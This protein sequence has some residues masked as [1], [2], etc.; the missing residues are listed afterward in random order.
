MSKPYHL[1]FR[2]GERATFGALAGLVLGFGIARNL[3]AIVATGLFLQ[4]YAITELPLVFVTGAGV[5]AGCWVIFERL[6]RATGPRRARSIASTL[7]TASLLLCWGLLTD[8]PTDSALMGAMVWQYGVGALATLTSWGLAAR[9]YAVRA[10]RRLFAPLLGVDLISGGIAGLMAWFLPA[11]VQPAHLVAVAAASAGAGLLCLTWSPLAPPLKPESDADEMLSITYP[12]KLLAFLGVSAI[13]SQLLHF[14]FLNQAD[15]AFDS[16]SDLTRFLGLVGGLTDLATAGTLVV[17]APRLLGVVGI[18]ATILLIPVMTTWSMSAAW[19]V[20]RVSG[21]G[22][23]FLWAVT[24]VLVL[25]RLLRG[26][27][28]QTAVHAL[29]QPLT[30]RVR[31]AARS[32]ADTVITPLAMGGTGAVLLLFGPFWDEPEPLIAGMLGVLMAWAIGAR[33]IGM[34]YREAIDRSFRLRCLWGEHLLL[35]DAQALTVLAEA[36]RSDQAGDA[37]YGL[38]L[39]EEVDHPELGP[40]LVQQLAHPVPTVRRDALSRLGDRRPAGLS[41][42]LNGLIL[43]ENDPDVLAVAARVLLSMEEVAR[44]SIN[45][46][47]DH[48]NRI[49]SRAALAGLSRHPNPAESGIAWARAGELAASIRASHRREAARTLGAMGGTGPHRLLAMLFEDADASVRRAAIRAAGHCDHPAIWAPLVERL[50]TAEAR[51]PAFAALCSLGPRIVPALVERFALVQEPAERLT[52]VRTA[53]RVGGDEA[54][55][56]LLDRLADPE[57]ETR[58]QAA[59]ALTRARLNPVERE[60][61]HRHILDEAAVTA[62]LLTAADDIEDRRL[63]TSLLQDAEAAVS[64]TLN[65]LEAQGWSKAALQ[66]RWLR[67][68]PDGNH[69]LDAP[70]PA[71]LA[72][73]AVPMV[74][75]D[76]DRLPCLVDICGEVEEPDGPWLASIA[77]EPHRGLSRWSRLCAVDVI[78]RTRPAFGRA[79]LSSLCNDNDHILAEA[80]ERALGRLDGFNR[81]EIT[82]AMLQPLERVLLLKSIGLFSSVSEDALVSLSGVLDELRLPAGTQVTRE[83]EPG[84]S[85]YFVVRGRLRVHEGD[86]TVGTL[87]P[88]QVIGEL[89]VLDPRPRDASVTSESEVLLLRLRR[90]ALQELATT[91]GEVAWG[92]IAALCQKLRAQQPELVPT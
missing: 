42:A 89:S 34:A 58:D 70:I 30:P 87:G 33:R 18:R 49:V 29:H 92:I 85:M 31:A 15:Q 88:R 43:S 28:E 68:Q 11:D 86:R 8:T 23:N 60:R 2:E 51:A 76:D 35:R 74:L 13:A 77:T 26:S 69:A 65:L 12:S 53:A 83:G 62:W 40:A 4:R 67:A 21:E 44:P 63:V 90:E 46:L 66:L 84:L 75:R 47:L 19:W 80:A 7:L 64:R 36:L 79:V 41:N 14:L 20:H 17:L 3:F 24:G 61:V 25:D 71:D 54:R 1:E 81:S 56:F 16:A 55:H 78:T 45:P 48:P 91:H 39:L 6:E 59:G 82:T 72:A 27:L 73:L 38:H 22:G 5:I 10:Q 57:R 52:I 32:T 37:L 9:T 50:G